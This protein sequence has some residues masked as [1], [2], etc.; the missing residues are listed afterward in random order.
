MKIIQ[1]ME[2]KNTD[3]IILQKVK[4]NPLPFTRYRLVLRRSSH[5]NRKILNPWCLEVW[6]MTLVVL[7]HDKLNP[8]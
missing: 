1:E 7:L 5:V 3:E 4:N 6:V 8:G 2:E